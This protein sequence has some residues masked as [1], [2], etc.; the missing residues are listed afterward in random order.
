M[1]LKKPQI[2]G[3]RPLPAREFAER[4]PVSFDLLAIGG[5]VLGVSERDHCGERDVCVRCYESE[6]L[7]RVSREA[8][9]VAASRFTGL[10]RNSTPNH[11]HIILVELHP[12]H[13]P[14]I[15]SCFH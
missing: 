8:Y 6:A 9:Y 3:R 15:G 4:L 5:E 2:G 7:P 10:G 12:D 1:E 14:H 11:H 13:G